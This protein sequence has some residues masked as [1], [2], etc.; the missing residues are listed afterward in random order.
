MTDSAYPHRTIGHPSVTL[1]G[2]EKKRGRREEERI[3]I[4]IR[5]SASQKK[6]LEGAARRIGLTLSSW[7]R[8]V[9]LRAEREQRKEEGK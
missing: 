1:G 6:L 3:V 4:Q 7:L 8:M 9:A 5:I 2:M